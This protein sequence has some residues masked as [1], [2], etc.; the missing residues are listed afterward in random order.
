MARRKQRPVPRWQQRMASAVTPEDRLAITYDRLRALLADL[1]RKRR[2]P[3]AQRTGRATAATLASDAADSLA[4]LC[5]EIERTE[6][7][8]AA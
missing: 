2:D 7:G 3:F 8:H 6:K 5:E 1:S 4:R